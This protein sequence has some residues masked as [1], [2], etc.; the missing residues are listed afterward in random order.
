MTDPIDV[1]GLIDIHVHCGPSPF[2]RRTDGY[3]CAREAANAGM[4]AV[5]LKEHHLPTAYGVPYI[6]R[7]LERDGLEVDVI[8]SVVLNYCNGGF[9][10]FAV[11]SAIAYGADVIWGPTIDARHHA[12]QTG[13]LGAF[14]GVDAGAEYEDRDGISALEDGD[15]TAD[16]RLCLDKVIAHD[17]VFCLGHLSYE[18]TVAIVDYLAEAGH[19]RIVVDHPNYG[20][21]DLSIDQQRTLAERG[22][23]LNFLFMGLSPKY[24]WISS[25]ELYE[26]IREIG[27][28]RC[29]LSSDVGQQVNPSSPESLRILGETLRSEGLSESEFRTMAGETPR[30]LLFE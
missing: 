6:D 10:P 14:L 9:N 20:V 29:V 24:S 7:L 21:T 2:D 26:N 28:D 12:E 1:S 22:A 23:Y 30:S 27:V 11:E 13:S 25:E 3:E 18:E 5:V 8:G 15:L 19:E 4:D 16:V 17:V